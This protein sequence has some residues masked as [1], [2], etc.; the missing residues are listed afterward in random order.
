VQKIHEKFCCLPAKINV[1]VR[2]KA[3]PFHRCKLLN[4]IF[5]SLEENISR[6]LMKIQL[7]RLKGVFN[8]SV[9]F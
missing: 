9:E 6:I 7:V 3:R 8:M 2:Q 1:K 4:L 5:N